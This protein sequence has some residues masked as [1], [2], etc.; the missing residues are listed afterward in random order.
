MINDHKGH[1]PVKDESR[2]EIE[3]PLMAGVEMF[4]FGIYFS[5]RFVN[6]FFGFTHFLQKQ[7]CS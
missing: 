1:P 6:D 5:G 2:F 4:Y 3:H 7:I